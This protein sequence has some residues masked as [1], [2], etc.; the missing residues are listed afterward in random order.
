MDRIHPIRAN[1]IKENLKDM[2]D[3]RRT[4]RMQR[5]WKEVCDDERVLYHQKRIDFL[6]REIQVATKLLDGGI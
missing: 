1:M 3:L 6:Y 5:K 4:K 2:H